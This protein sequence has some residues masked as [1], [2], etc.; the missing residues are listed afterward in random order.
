M[1]NW[2]AAFEVMKIATHLSIKS[3]IQFSAL[4]LCIYTVCTTAF[5]SLLIDRI[6]AVVESDV[7]T[8]NELLERVNVIRAQA[9]DQANLPSDDI[10]AEQVLNRMIIERLQ[11]DWGQRRGIEIDDLSLDQ[12]MR[13]LAQRNSLTLDQFR[14][15]L[16]QQGIDYV[17]FR[18]Q[19]R[20]EMLIQQTLRRGVD[21]NVQVSEQE[22]DALLDSQKDAMDTNAEYRLSHILIQLPQDPT[23][24][25]I[26]KAKNEIEEIRSQ[27]VAGES[28]TQLAIARSQA[29]D[30]L[31]GG[32]LGWRNKSQMPNMFARQ[33]STMRPGEISEVLR[34]GSGFHIFRILDVR[35]NERVMVKQVLSRH[36]LI[37]T[38]AIR[39]DAEVEQDLKALRTR[40]SNGE[41]FAE[42]ARVHSE[43]PASAVEGGDLGWLAPSVFAPAFRDVAES[44]E[45]N[46]V[47]QPFK[48]RFGWH[49]MQVLDKREHDNS[50]EA[51][52]NQAREF[53]RQRKMEEETEIWLRQLRDES[54]VENRL[55]APTED[56]PQ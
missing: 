49:I 36:I 52:R 39:E 50:I 33:V 5:A 30:A 18:E 46:E 54:Y 56:N 25:D 3:I 9:G 17:S 16:L 21:A 6:V 45:V 38:N 22:I 2:S 28:F 15:A 55:L 4:T 34:S 8:E 24:E 7:I 11:V 44:I 19:V 12:A 48:S 14:D 42:L 47:S 1:N 51:R 23:P 27:A 13:N 43:D 31:E 32:D 10:L 29:Q 53:L 35:G 40:I 41:D 26:D 37:R 20:T